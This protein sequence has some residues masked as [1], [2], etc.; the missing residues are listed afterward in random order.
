MENTRLHF[1]KF[2]EE[3]EE[4]VNPLVMV[5]E[6]HAFRIRFPSKG[7]PIGRLMVLFIGFDSVVSVLFSG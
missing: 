2:E 4:E 5:E 1:E 3:E 7:R 6:S